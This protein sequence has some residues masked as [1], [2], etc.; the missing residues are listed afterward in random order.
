MSDP[1]IDTENEAPPV[2]HEYDAPNGEYVASDPAVSRADMPDAV[3]DGRLGE[4]CQQRLSHFPL[5]YSW[6]SLVTAA[7]AL[8]PRCNQPPIRTNLFWCPVGPAGTGKSQCMD[9]V[10]HLLEL[11]TSPVLLEAKFG[12]AEALVEKLEGIGSDAVR[13]VSVD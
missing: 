2:G 12:S 8:I 10:F 9:T 7:G 5:A 3:L 1:R 13:L 4:I 11:D 6:G